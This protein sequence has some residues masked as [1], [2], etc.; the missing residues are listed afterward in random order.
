MGGFGS[1]F[2]SDLGKLLT[3]GLGGAAGGFAT[4]S[5]TSGSSATTSQQQGSSDSYQSFTNFLNSLLSSQQQ[6][7]SSNTSTTTPNL[8]PSTQSLIDNLTKRYASLSTPSLSGYQAQQTQGINRSADLQKQSVNNIMASRGL[9]QS[10]VSGTAEANVE[11]RRI[12]QINNLNASLP[13]LKNQ[14]DVSN[15]GAAT[16]F[17]NAVPHGTTTTS[18]GTTSQAGTQSN[19]QNTGGVSSGTQN[20]SSTGTQQTNS[21]QNTQ[22]GGGVGSAIGG[23]ASLLASL[24]SDERLKAEIKPIDKAVDKIMAL[25]PVTW[26]WKGGSVE[27]AGLL[28]QDLL[29]TLPEL[30][31]KDPEGSG[32]N[33]V[34]YAGLLGTLVAAVQELHTEAQ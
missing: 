21:N 12:G 33:K 20:T 23:F 25:H 34:N 10:P 28:A 14:L 19:L 27:D 11:A 16:N 29:K 31:H 32:Y 9:A 5:S 17:L 22:S 4:P 8:S 26:K 7:T 2:N 24:F 18:G 6:G 3:A 15:L 13:L 30:V 1:F